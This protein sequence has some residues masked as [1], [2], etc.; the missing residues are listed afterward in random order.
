MEHIS[1]GSIA[2][3][4]AKGLQRSTR[5]CACLAIF[6]VLVIVAIIVVAVIQ[7]WKNSSIQES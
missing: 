2:L 5:K 7:P 6:I 1:A 4:K 3:Q